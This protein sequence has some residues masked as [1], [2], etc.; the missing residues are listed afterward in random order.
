MPEGPVPTT[1]QGTSRPGRRIAAG[2]S[3]PF[4]KETIPDPF[5]VSPSQG[6]SACKG[7]P[8]SPNGPRKGESLFDSCTTRLPFLSLPVHLSG[9][10]WTTRWW[11][12]RCSVKK[13]YNIMFNKSTKCF[14][15]NPDTKNPLGG[16][17]RGGGKRVFRNPAPII[18]MAGI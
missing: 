14:C 5:V 12:A 1:E 6:P 16:G 8:T 15:W 3:D 2:R 18:N 7:L 4:L 10:C 17:R 13:Y 9:T 11:G